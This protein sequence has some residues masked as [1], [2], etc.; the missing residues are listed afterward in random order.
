[1]EHATDPWLAALVMVGLLVAAGIMMASHLRV[2]RAAKYDELPRREH[3]YH[4]RRFR[5]RM[6]SSA[7]VGLTGVAV[8]IGRWIE[9]P[10]AL[11]IG[12]W[13]GVLLL[14]TWLGLLAVADIV[15]TAH[16]FGRLRD[17]YLVERAKLEAVVRRMRSTE[18]NGHKRP[19]DPPV[20]PAP[21]DFGQHRDSP[22]NES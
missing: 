4:R 21:P 19:D 18:G 20:P 1:M 12:Y 8:F 6:Q 17:D 13:S 15:S 2:W 16:H 5:R 10:P 14:V 7:M 9:G 11:V 22:E 3:E